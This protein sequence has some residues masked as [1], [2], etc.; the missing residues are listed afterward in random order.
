M[1][2]APQIFSRVKRHTLAA[3]HRF[4]DA[5]HPGRI[6]PVYPDYVDPQFVHARILPTWEKPRDEAGT[7]C[8]QMREI[9]SLVE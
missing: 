5:G 3:R 8:L 4:H 2:G 7:Y 6:A 1:E 9:L